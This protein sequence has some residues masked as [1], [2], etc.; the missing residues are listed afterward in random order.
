MMTGQDL[1]PAGRVLGLM[2]ALAAGA[3]TWWSP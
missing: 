2:V 1:D 3:A